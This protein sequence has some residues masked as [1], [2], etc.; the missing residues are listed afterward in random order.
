MN[1]LVTGSSGFLGT[2]LCTYLEAQ[3]CDLV[4]LTSKNC[5]LR[6]PHSLDRFDDREYSLIF[7]LAAW[8]Q[9]G[10]FCL[11]HPG[12]QWIINQQINTNTLAWWAR[13]QPQAKMVIMGTSCAY[14]PGSD[15]RETEYMAGEPIDSLY[16]Y[17]MTK[18]MLYQGVRALNRQYGLSYLCAV[19]S[20]LYGPGYHAD[21]R[22][23]HFIFDLIRKIIRGREF[24]EPVVLWGDGW[25]RREV[26]LVDDFAR[27]LW[28]LVCEQDN[29]IF[30]IGAGEEHS[31]RTFASKICTIVG[32]SEDEIVYDE[33]RYIGATSKCLNVEKAR[34]ALPRYTLHSL[35]D[36]LR[37]TI[38]WFYRT[39]A[40]L[41]P[42]E[43]RVLDDVRASS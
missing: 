10:D 20:T 11:H 42:E 4:R 32:Y 7:H 15:L 29:D 31:I 35:D 36:G 13:S 19:P 2:A 39:Q 16:T 21:G 43:R 18:R 9:A 40:Y 37:A 3:G 1:V 8:T 25:Q 14:A 33:Q 34:Q 30:N 6:D 12:D 26:V 17:A 27:L 24:R 28:N 23:M 38:D 22:Q 41:T 5:D